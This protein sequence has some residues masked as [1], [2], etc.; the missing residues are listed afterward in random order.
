MTQIIAAAA[1]F[2][3][4][5]FS[6]FGVG[7]GTLLMI[8]MVNFASLSQHAA[9]GINLLYF[10]PTSLTAL[11]SHIKNKL[12]DWQMAVPAILAGL[13]SALATAFIA[14]AIDVEILKKF[15]GFFLILVGLYEFF[16]KG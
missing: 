13:L 7:G 15:F 4:G 9:Q 10:L 14:T 12:I 1:G 6:G 11:S 8:Y 3:C 2:I 16:K 5:V